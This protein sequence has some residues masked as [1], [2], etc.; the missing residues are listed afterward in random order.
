MTTSQEI[1]NFIHYY[2]TIA[3]DRTSRMLIHE[4]QVKMMKTALFIP[5]ALMLVFFAP[6]SGAE[7]MTLNV[8]P[9]VVD[10][11]DLMIFTSLKAKKNFL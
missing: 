7:V 11:G 1:N 6:L 8:S 5:V 10:T 9:L 2:N 4:S 3:C